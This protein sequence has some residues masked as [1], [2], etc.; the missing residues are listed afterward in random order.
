MTAFL[1]LWENVAK[2]KFY[3]GVHKGTV[4]DGYVCSCKK[5]LE[6][7]IDNPEHFKRLVL[8]YGS[9][10]DMILLE[11]KLLAKVDA[12]RN[13]S[14][15]NAHNGDGKFFNKGHTRQLA[16]RMSL[17]K[18][19]T[20]MPPRSAAYLKMLSERAK[21]RVR[22]EEERSKISKTKKQRYDSSPELKELCRQRMLSESNVF[23][24][25]KWYTNGIINVRRQERPE[26]FWFGRT[27]KN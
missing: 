6:D 21:A 17:I 10:A 13:N 23:R 27:A 7:Y 20:K 9:Y 16:A 11:S 18:T 26:G 14:Y 1:Y 8:A 15:Y 19:G 25:S 12:K 2:T 5:M 4:N 24:G 3:I 22:S